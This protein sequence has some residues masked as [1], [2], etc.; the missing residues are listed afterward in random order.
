MNDVLINKVQS[1]QR[2][3]LRAIEEYNLAGEGLK[4]DFSR[5]DACLL[6]ILRAC[7]QSIDLANHLVK[8]YKLGIPTQSTDSFEFLEA[9][10]LSEELSLSLQKMV[11]FRDTL[12]HSYQKLQIEIVEVLMKSRLADLNA[13]T[14]FA[15]KF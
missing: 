12:V 7:E 15:V 3:I 6:N 5:Q 11:G 4:K 14:E 13:F 10:G 1:I 8:K 9:K 2:C